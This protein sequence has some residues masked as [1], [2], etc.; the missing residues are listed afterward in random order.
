MTTNDRC[1][2]CAEYRELAGW[3]IALAPRL[4]SFVLILTAIAL[5]A[6]AQWL[7]DRVTQSHS[8]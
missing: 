7:S 3:L 2:R 5:A 1:P 6:G 8:D 4:V